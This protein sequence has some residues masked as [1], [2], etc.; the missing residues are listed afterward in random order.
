MIPDAP[1]T[2]WCTSQGIKSPLELKG[3]G[4]GYRYLAAKNDISSEEALLSVPLD[5]CVIDDT[6]EGLAERLYHERSLGSESKYDAYIGVLPDLDSFAS[7]PRFWSPD[8]LA[9]VSDFDGG[10]LE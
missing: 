7:M 6:K 3:V 5:A 4:S 2:S 1:F 8:R 10:Q 9:R